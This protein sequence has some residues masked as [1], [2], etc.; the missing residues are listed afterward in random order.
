[1]MLYYLGNNDKGEILYVFNTDTNFFP[2][3]FNTLL[4]DSVDMEP[5]GIEG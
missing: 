3:I 4:V 2:N 1:M 5:A